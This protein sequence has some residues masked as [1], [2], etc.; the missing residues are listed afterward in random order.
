MRMGFQELSTF[1][2]SN[3]PTGLAQV[4]PFNDLG[5]EWVGRTRRRRARDRPLAFFCGA[6][7]LG[8]QFAVSGGEDSRGST[9]PHCRRGG[10]GL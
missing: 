10:R 7:R 3:V 2:K 6:K 9:C 5:D 8:K 4:S 1:V